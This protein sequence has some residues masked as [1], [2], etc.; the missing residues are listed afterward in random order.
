MAANPL[1]PLSRAAALPAIL[2]ALTS[3]SGLIAD[4]AAESARP[5]WSSVPGI[6]ID[7]SPAATRQYVGSPS[8]AVLPN[9]EYIAGHDWFGPGSSNNRTALFRSRDRG[10]SW[11]RIVE[12]EGQWWSSL[13]FHRGALYLLGTSG[14]NG[15]CVI[16]R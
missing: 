11:S 14:E 2:M 3:I 6:V 8:L 7:H 5:D 15:L 16:R 12:L 9:G 10:Q 1:K 4:D 13:F